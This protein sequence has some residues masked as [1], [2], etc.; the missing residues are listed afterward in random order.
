MIERQEEIEEVDYDR[1]KTL[2]IVTGIVCAL[3]F[4]CGTALGGYHSVMAIG[5]IGVLSVACYL[6]ADAAVIWSAYI[7]YKESGT[8]MEWA[9]WGV[10]YG[11]SLYL[12]VSGGCIVYVLI[13][14]TEAETGRQSRS[15]LYQKTYDDCMGQPKAKAR[16]CRQLASEFNAG[17]AKAE[18]QDRETKKK[19][20]STVEWYVNL[21]LFKYI[22]GILGLVG[23]FILTLVSKLQRPR[24]RRFRE[25]PSDG[26]R[27]T[28][29][30]LPAG[31]NARLQVSPANAP[32]RVGSLPAQLPALPAVTNGNGFTFSFKASGKGYQLHYRE[33][34]D[35]G[36]SYVCNL[37]RSQAEGLSVADYETVALYGMERRRQK[38]GDDALV[39]RIAASL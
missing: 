10:K 37:A 28:P 5:F 12:L 24:K 35:S 29:G 4:L 20:N 32:L 8:P 22:P 15:G 7:D 39:L 3:I 18:T 2:A 33:R 21:P 13:G 38:F 1:E 9:A 34:G 23:L 6:I 11:L 31:R 17:E 27:E 14:S 16:D 25:T 26:N 19:E 36:S 30:T